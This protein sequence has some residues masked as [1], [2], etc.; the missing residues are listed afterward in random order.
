MADNCLICNLEVL[1]DHQAFACDECDRWQ[2]LSCFDQVFPGEF[3]QAV[4]DGTATFPWICHLHDSILSLPEVVDETN[5]S[6]VGEVVDATNPPDVSE[7]VDTT[8]P[9][10]E[11]MDVT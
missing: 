8:N 1:D 7:V 10:D 6:Y 5:L 3:Y 4:V 9:L 11:V 2:H